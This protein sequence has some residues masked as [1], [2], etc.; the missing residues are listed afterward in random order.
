MINGA[1]T[2]IE[3]KTV[4]GRV[5]ITIKDADIMTSIT[6]TPAQV[7]EQASIIAAY[8]NHAEVSK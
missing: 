1:G 7:R 6:L 4:S 2:I 3:T 8:A 5:L